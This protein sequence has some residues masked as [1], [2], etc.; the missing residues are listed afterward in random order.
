M[1]PNEGV[2]FPDD[3]SAL[4]REELQSLQTQ[5]LIEFDAL[6]EN[7]AINDAGV[8]RLEVLA[9]GI[10]ALTTAITAL[11]AKTVTAANDVKKVADIRGRV[12][13]SRPAAKPAET[14]TETAA[15]AE[16]HVEPEAV[17][18]S[19]AAEV[20][21]TRVASLAAATANAPVIPAKSGDDLVI[22]AAAATSG[23]QIGSRFEDSDSLVAAFQGIARSLA[24]S[25]GNPSFQSV[26]S[27]KNNFEFVIDGLG[28]KPNDIES[29]LRDLRSRDRQ[30]ALVAGGGWCAPSEIRYDFF[31]I[32]C[33]DGMVDLPTVGVRR[34]G[35]QFPNSPSLA[36]VFTGAFT[37]ATNPWLWTEAD[38]TAAA[39]GS[40]TKPCVRV[41]C[42]DFEEVRLECYGICLT[43]GNLTDY[44]YP[45][46][47]RNHLSLLM[48]AH[49]HAMNQRYLTQMVNLSTF[50][51][52]IPAATGTGILS[53][54]PAATALAADD[55][56]TRYGMCDDDVLEV[57]FPRWVKDAMRIDHLRRNGFWASPLS[58]ADINRLFTANRVRVQ[59]VND[60][61]VRAVGQPGNATPLVDWPATV[62]FMIYAAGTF[63]RGNGLSLDLGVVR[64]SVL[65]E[66]NDHTAAWTEE[67]HLIA[68]VG[69]ESR[70]YTIP[71]CTAG[72]TGAN[73]VVCASVAGT[74]DPS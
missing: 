19:S 60:W 42:P 28:T 63:I 29:L 22:T 74:S 72:R 34:G 10:E 25:H 32:A 15:P 31:N 48:A 7:E 62:D 5:A 14:K 2:V 51:G 64:D 52:Q 4:T 12:A 20:K 24:P 1:D 39:T 23:V 68:R 53:D 35:I 30:E 71:V 44:A 13:K 43:A 49:Y 41:D 69:H 38:D 47:T 67:C 45:E 11:D 18:A 66:T 57:V 40:P 36:D 37:N 59:W 58:D 33:Q 21:I 61:Q 46:A 3:L 50:A 65:N 6:A 27:I 16:A 17:T 55:Y 73:D 70:Y 54:A 8:A 9:G 56:R 26:A